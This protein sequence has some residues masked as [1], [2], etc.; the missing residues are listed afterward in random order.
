M[1]LLSITVVG[2]HSA[3]VSLRVLA[4]LLPLSDERQP[5]GGDGAPINSLP[6]FSA[7]ISAIAAVT[8]LTTSVLVDT[9]CRPSARPLQGKDRLGRRDTCLR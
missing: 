9:L 8:S 1:T 7:F 4:L 5:I 2:R 3:P 6:R